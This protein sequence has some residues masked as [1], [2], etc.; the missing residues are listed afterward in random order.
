M[1]E[2]KHLHPAA[3]NE[4]QQRFESLAKSANSKLE[5]MG[6]I[7][8]S[9]LSLQGEKMKMLPEVSTCCALVVVLCECS[10]V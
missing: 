4:T 9:E 7:Q 5:Q 8:G 10:A 1:P 6:V 3:Y 2:L